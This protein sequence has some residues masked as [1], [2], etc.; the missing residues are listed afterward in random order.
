MDHRGGDGG[1]GD[2]APRH[3]IN[4]RRRTSRED[5]NDGH[6]EDALPALPTVALEAR[7]SSTIR[8]TA[9]SSG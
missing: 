8:N 7:C 4:R 1:Q 3:A 2:G 5:P 9:S 6:K